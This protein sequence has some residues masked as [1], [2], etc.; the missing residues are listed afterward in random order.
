MLSVHYM[1]QGSCQS[2]FFYS[3]QRPICTG[4][5]PPLWFWVRHWH[6][7]LPLRRRLA[8]K[9]STRRAIPHVTNEMVHPCNST[10]NTH[11]WRLI[12]QKLSTEMVGIC[13]IDSVE[14]STCFP[15]WSNWLTS[16][17]LQLNWQELVVVLKSYNPMLYSYPSVSTCSG[18]GERNRKQK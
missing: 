10:I 7:A 12:G 4:V 17:T 9:A 11:M 1:L 14:L 16:F 6:P 18:T 13:F 15:S 2:P 5:R 3:R 8:R